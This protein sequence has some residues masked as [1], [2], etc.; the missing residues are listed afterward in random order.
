MT[1]EFLTVPELAELLRIKERKVYDLA[2]SGDV[3][4]TRATGKLLFPEAEVR[5]WISGKKTGASAQRPNV[6]LGSHDPLLEWALRQSECGLATYLDGSTDGLT[7]FASGEGIAAALHIRDAE[8]EAWN[9]PASK[10]AASDQNAVLISWV[11]R[12]RGLVMRPDMAGAIRGLP[13]ISGRRIAARQP[14]SGTANLLASLLFDA[15]LDTPQ[16][17]E[18][19]HSEQDAV[20][21]VLEGSADVT[22]GLEAMAAR[23]GLAYLPLVTERFDILVD[24]TA[25][26]EP[27][28]Q[29]FLTFC[30]GAIFTERAKALKGYDATALGG[31]LWNA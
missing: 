30:K 19:F 3:P 29:T 25:Y 1:T 21:A 11:T 22:L 16:M 8:T 4:C 26:F 9:I 14:G 7:R 13:D 10:T 27:P 31:V 2:A 18:P 15:G 24:R 28:F 5:V 17:T 23:F 12:S 6:F 20:L